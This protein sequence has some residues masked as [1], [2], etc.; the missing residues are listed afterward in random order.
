MGKRERGREQEMNG[1]IEG[2]KRER[3]WEKRKREYEKKKREERI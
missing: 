3:E 1:K 2:K